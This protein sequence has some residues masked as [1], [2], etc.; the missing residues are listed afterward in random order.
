M[1]PGKRWVPGQICRLCGKNHD[2][3]KYDACGDGF[4]CNGH[5]LRPL[6]DRR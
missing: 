5:V 4:E 1:F 3:K 2:G 6:E